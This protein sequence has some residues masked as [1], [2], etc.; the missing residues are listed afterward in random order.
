[1]LNGL[2]LVGKEIGNIK[3]VISGAVVDANTRT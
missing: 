2:K 1:V 3:A